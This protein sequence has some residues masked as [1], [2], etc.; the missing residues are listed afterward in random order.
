MSGPAL[1]CIDGW[2]GPFYG[3]AVLPLLEPHGGRTLLAV[4]YVQLCKKCGCKPNSKLL[5]MFDQIMPAEESFVDQLDLSHNYL[6]HSGLSATIDLLATLPGLRHLNLSLCDVQSEHIAAL[7]R[8]AA[9]HPGLR[10]LDLSRNPLSVASCRAIVEMLNTNPNLSHVALEDT[11]VEDDW[12]QRIQKLC[13]R[14]VQR[15]QTRPEAEGPCRPFGCWKY[16]RVFL[17][18]SHALALPELTYFRTAVVPR[19]NLL[20]NALF[21]RFIPVHLTWDLSHGI[22]QPTLRTCQ[23]A[24][25]GCRDI[26]NHSLP[27]FIIFHVQSPDIA[28]QEDTYPKLPLSPSASRP[29]DGAS[30]A[31]SL[32]RI[33]TS[34]GLLT[35]FG[36]AAPP[37]CTSTVFLLTCAAEGDAKPPISSPRE[38]GKSPGRPS[39]VLAITSWLERLRQ[40][41]VVQ[42]RWYPPGPAGRA[43][44]DL[45][46]LT[47]LLGVAQAMYGRLPPRP[48]TPYAPSKVVPPA[49]RFFAPNDFC[50]YVSQQQEAF[51]RWKAQHYSP[52]LGLPLH[53]LLDTCHLET[54]YLL[55][56]VGP[57]G[58]GKSSLLAQLCLECSRSDW[59]L[60]YYFAGAT[61]SSTLIQDVLLFLYAKLCAAMHMEV[62]LNALTSGVAVD[63]PTLFT[64]LLQEPPPT[65]IMVLID[66]VDA[67][68]YRCCAGPIRHPTGLSEAALSWIPHSFHHKI[69]M[70]FCSSTQSQS[71]QLLRQRPAPPFELSLPALM[72]ADRPSCPIRPFVVPYTGQRRV[73]S[74]E[75]TTD[76][77]LRT[78][79][80]Y[81]EQQLVVWEEDYGVACVK[82]VLLSLAVQPE[83]LP[84][85]ELEAVS[86]ELLVEDVSDQR[87]N[88][89]KFLIHLLPICYI[90]PPGLVQLTVSTLGTIVQRRY[91]IGP[92]AVARY[93]SAVARYQRAALAAKDY[94]FLRA[95]T[96]LPEALM[97]SGDLPGAYDALTAI[98]VIE[99]AIQAGLYWQ[100]RRDYDL[101]VGEM[102]AAGR[103]SLEA[104]EAEEDGEPAEDNQWQPPNH[105][106]GSLRA[107]TLLRYADLLRQHQPFL[108]SHPSACQLGCTLPPSHPWCSAVDH[109][110]AANGIPY[111]L[112]VQ[113]NRGITDE[114]SQLTLHGHTAAVVH[115]HFAPSGTSLVTTS[116]C[117]E[118]LEWDAEHGV[119]L[120]SLALGGGP[121]WLAALYRPDGGGVISV[122]EQEMGWWTAGFFDQQAELK[123]YVCSL[124]PNA[125]NPAGRTMAA[126]D[127]ST[128]NV[129]LVDVLD[130]TVVE[131]LVEGREGQ[132]SEV[133]F[134]AQG[135]TLLACRGS[136]ILVIGEGRWGTYQ[137]NGA[138]V[139]QIVTSPDGALVATAHGSAIHV[140]GC[141]TQQ[142][143]QVL[144][145]HSGN[146]TALCFSDTDSLLLSGSEDG[147]VRV[148]RLSDGAAVKELGAETQGPLRRT[149]SRSNVSGAKGNAV[150]LQPVPQRQRVGWCS[151]TSGGRF[152][153][154][155]IESVVVV[156][157]G[158]TYDWVDTLTGHGDHINWL[159]VNPISDVVA[160]ASD[161]RS[162]KVWDLR[163][164]STFARRAAS[165][166][167]LQTA[168]AHHTAVQSLDVSA[169]GLRLCTTSR[170]GDLKVWQL[171][172]PD[173]PLIVHV[174][175]GWSLPRFMPG[176]RGAHGLIAARS[177]ALH[178]MNADT[179]VQDYT[180]PMT[181]LHTAIFALA[182]APTGKTVA[183]LLHV[184]NA[185]EVLVLSLPQGDVVA[186][187]T[188][189]NELAVGLRF[190][191]PTSLL[192]YTREGTVT[193]WSLKAP[194]TGNASL[195]SSASPLAGPV[196]YAD[197]TLC[198]LGVRD[199]TLKV[200]SLAGTICVATL[201]GHGL[202]V[203]C[204]DLSP[205]GRYLLSGAEDH[206]IRLWQAAD[207][208]CAALFVCKGVPTAVRFVPRG[209][210]E[211]GAEAPDRVI[212]A[213]STGAVNI[214][215]IIV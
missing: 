93:W 35:Q 159:A 74:S 172:D 83:G 210:D 61:P 118:V 48:A 96:T 79:E 44:L 215:D 78:L 130:G 57:P 14:N 38:A 99:H 121:F 12:R 184:R 200:V 9:G 155:R 154:A 43:G 196:L 49:L 11:A 190:L 202:P 185:S 75:D 72:P 214:F 122:A 132:V 20:L 163:A 139:S 182:A 199:G 160:T 187:F 98:D 58:W 64:E 76:D 194:T 170:D 21:L 161:D 2:V 128:S 164:C 151:F 63:L 7:Q 192:S 62:L 107:R 183:L 142:P 89:P 145:G 25:D 186:K 134:T 208:K 60:V 34:H 32:F 204:A 144:L 140:W 143:I 211:F 120:R 8:V 165:T 117:G 109:L 171:D 138:P 113:C 81:F 129:H 147:T 148:W 68:D 126:V 166:A 90:G 209:L 193:R 157:D 177:K 31:L 26:A 141:A 189:T 191:S 94:R 70:V 4:R 84:V 18:A 167:I 103:F 10:S 65:N 197:A 168:T 100:L 175:G 116:R 112:L 106:R 102:A 27:W 114:R 95:L 135:S 28:L 156:W 80:N 205:R 111:P 137:S 15:S 180:V 22:T 66:G 91:H 87:E 50:L 36:T 71:L 23:A 169:D 153:V 110:S 54:P 149:S 88:V 82:A 45:I 152:I 150:L 203:V 108:R 3:A 33:E 29:D 133:V 41:P 67:I 195:L 105:F 19:M 213:D 104:N 206:T 40:C 30:T 42:Q 188:H 146:V 173:G 13:Q 136:D 97:R 1:A 201:R 17:S 198:V 125:F 115:A 119:M 16:I 77:S 39:D 59:Q 158:R 47:D 178:F 123:G 124:T 56:L 131:Q 5:E 176:P 179:G 51:V 6:G 162:A 24:I 52:Q 92:T 69:R 55:F 86:V 174:A 101:L 37:G 73:M 207:W 212:A 127:V 85:D 53:A 181:A 46:A